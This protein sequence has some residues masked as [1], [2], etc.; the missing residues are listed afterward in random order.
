VP[1]TGG[2]DSRLIVAVLLLLKV[3]TERIV[4]I[5]ANH[6]REVRPGTDAWIA[7]KVAEFAGYKHIILNIE[8]LEIDRF[9]ELNALYGEGYAHI[10]KEAS[11]WEQLRQDGIYST[12]NVVLTGDRFSLRGVVDED[13]ERIMDK[14][15][16]YDLSMIPS[17]FGFLPKCIREELIREYSEWYS[18]LISHYGRKITDT[19]LR[20]KIYYEQ[21]VQYVLTTNRSRFFGLLSPVSFPLLDYNLLKLVLQLPDNMRTN[22]FYYSVI[23]GIHPELFRIPRDTVP[24]VSEDTDIL[25]KEEVRKQE[26]HLNKFSALLDCRQGVIEKEMLSAGRKT[27]GCHLLK[28][29]VKSML[30]AGHIKNMVSNRYSYLASRKEAGMYTRMAILDKYLENL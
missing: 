23:S 1:L 19:N 28:R 20:Q 21:R 25:V 17:T 10:E 7:R 9:A 11:G 15:Y 26:F 5:T 4:C 24:V 2:W 27:Y 6:S 3:P 22:E 30:P 12:D 13:L 16:M 18:H 14:L 8:E 29:V